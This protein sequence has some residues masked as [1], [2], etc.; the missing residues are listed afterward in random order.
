VPISRGGDY[1]FNPRPRAG[2]DGKSA[3]ATLV[4]K[5]FQSTPPRG[6]RRLWRGLAWAY[7]RCFN[8][9]PRAGGDCTNLKRADKAS[10]RPLQREPSLWRSFIAAGFV[11]SA[12]ER[13]WFAEHL[14]MRELLENCVVATGPRT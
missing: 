6:G 14:D 3:V 9:R 7:P 12:S 8:P 5:L 11:A 13:R 1:C 4:M 2:G 10:F